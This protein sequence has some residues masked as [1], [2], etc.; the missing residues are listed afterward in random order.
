MTREKIELLQEELISLQ[1]AASYLGYS[2]ERCLNLTGEE[3][4]PARTT[5]TT[6]NIAICVTNLSKRYQIYGTPYV[7]LM[8]FAI[9][10][11]LIL[12]G[13]NYAHTA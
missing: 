9:P 8:P 7:R 12:E 11:L 3:E 10:K 4:M 6:T 2:M 5:G 1:R 13:D